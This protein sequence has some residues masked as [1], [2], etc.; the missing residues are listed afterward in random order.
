MHAAIHWVDPLGMK[1]SKSEQLNT[2]ATGYS[3]FSSVENI[4][5]NF[6]NF[7]FN[8]KSVKNGGN[9][10]DFSVFKVNFGEYIPD[11][12]KNNLD[13][14]NSNV[15]DK[16]EHNY[17]YDGYITPS[18]KSPFYVLGYPVIYDSPI[19]TSAKITRVFNNVYYNGR[20]KYHEI[21]SGTKKIY[22]YSSGYCAYNDSKTS[23]V[24]GCSGSMVVNEN[25][26]IVGI[27]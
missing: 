19:K 9:A 17:F 2:P 15:F 16:Q 3:F 18:S 11:P 23:M 1:W 7:T 14:L 10:I 5:D 12:E 6:T 21:S 26:E 27:L 24:G 20:S 4:D 25:F 22:D 8:N 13:Y